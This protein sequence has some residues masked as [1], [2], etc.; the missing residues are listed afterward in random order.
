MLSCEPLA[1]ELAGLHLSTRSSQSHVWGCNII[2]SPTGHNLT[3]SSVPGAAL[4]AE[5]APAVLPVEV[6]SPPFIPQ[7]GRFAPLRPLPLTSRAGP[8]GLTVYLFPVS[9]GFHSFLTRKALSSHT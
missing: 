2:A 8:A 1:H 4:S 7:R 3:R 6:A 9:L 5:R